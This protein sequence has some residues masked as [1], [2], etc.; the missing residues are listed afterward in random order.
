MHSAVL[1]TGASRGF[2]RCLAIDFAREL[3]KD[4]LDLILWARQEPG[5]QETRRLVQDSLAASKNSGEIHLHLQ[6]VDLSDSS[7]YAPKL[8]SLL[9]Q[10]SSSH[11]DRVLLV[12]NAGALGRLGFAQ[13]CPPPAE[14]AT[15][16]E[17][18]LTSVVWINKRFLDVY[19]ASR[20]ELSG[21]QEA[22]ESTKLVIVNVSSR[23][24]IAPYQTLGLYCTAKAAR[25]MHFRV[26][27]TEQPI[28]KV[29]VLSYSPGAMDT[30]MQQTMRSS[31]LMAP[32]LSE[33]FNAMKDQGTLVSTS[34][35]SRRAV[36]AAITGDFESGRY[37]TFEDLDHLD[38]RSK[39]SID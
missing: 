24:A 2:G 32:N 5:L 10:L 25:E 16:W 15:H 30:N 18:N 13:E 33:W 8:E 6:A 26:L 29:T 38:D 28:S 9:T 34:Q 31:P 37:I 12:H 4:D 36:V 7:D 1:I 17:L 11:Y 35:S 39:N 20:H 19:G 21:N 23:S 27:A 3:A 22:T 14:L